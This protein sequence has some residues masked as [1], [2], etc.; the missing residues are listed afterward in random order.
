MNSNNKRVALQEISNYVSKSLN[1][2]GWVNAQVREIS[3]Q[4]GFSPSDKHFPSQSRHGI[5][6]IEESQI[7][8]DYDSFLASPLEE[9]IVFTEKQLLVDLDVCSISNV[10]SPNCS[11]SEFGIAIEESN[12]NCAEEDEEEELQI[13]YS[14]DKSVSV[15]YAKEILSHMEKL[16]IRFMPDYRHM[17][18]QPY[19]VTEM[20]ASVINWIVG[21]H[22]CI[23]LLPESLFLS[24]NVLDRFLSLQNVPASKMKLCGATALFIACKYEE[25][26]PPTVKDLEIVLEGEW[27]GEDICGME[28]YMLMVLQY[29]L[30]WP[31]PV[32]FLRLLTIVNKWESQLRIMIKYFLE[33]SLVEQR[34]SSLRASQLVATCAYT[35]Q[36]ILQEENWS[37]T[38]PQITGYDYMSLVSYVHL[39]LKCL[40]NPFDHHY[41]IYS[42]Y[43]TPYFHGISRQVHDWIATNTN[44]MAMDGS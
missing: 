10:Q 13:R 38:L 32:S 40:E 31:G 16:E 25:I 41:A 36:S 19:Y 2:K 18:A 20:R 26:H 30:G 3:L 15:E 37:N 14:A 42:K 35:G 29:Q 1:V 33:V 21:V 34:F 44:L 12:D 9:E 8:K 4:N 5:S 22:T 7:Q 6:S 28:K 43:A 27:I 39:L 17:S 24:I 23:N 11:V